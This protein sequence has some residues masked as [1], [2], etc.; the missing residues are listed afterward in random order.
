ME[1]LLLIFE[2]SEKTS[3][4]GKISEPSNIRIF[5]ASLVTDVGENN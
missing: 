3:K 2:G 1:K 5:V 4:V